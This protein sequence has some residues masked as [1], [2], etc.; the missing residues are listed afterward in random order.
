M[1][2]QKTK[3][4]AVNLRNR[5]YSYNYIAKFV[6]VSKSTLSD[7][8]GKIPFVP[9][10]HTIETIGKARSASGAKKHQIK[11]DSI[12]KAK[13]KSFKDIGVLSKRDLFMLGLAI[14]IGEGG[15]SHD[16]I[17]LVNAD[18]R[19]IK[20]SIKWFTEIC[21]IKTKQIKIRL[22]LYP[23]NNEKECIDYW[24][25]SIKIPKH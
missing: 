22:F 19:I 5:G 15:K 3:Q 9:N 17:R 11:L 1:Y 21:G 23:D 7:W 13:L 6:P 16:V 20:L 8:L 2:L 12:N 4:K 25:K 10:K 18:P 24:S 14:Y